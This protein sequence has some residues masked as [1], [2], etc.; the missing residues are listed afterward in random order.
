M[1]TNFGRTILWYPSPPLCFTNGRPI[2]SPEQ[3]VGRSP[4]AAKHLL[5]HTLSQSNVVDA[6]QEIPKRHS[7]VISASVSAHVRLCGTEDSDLRL[8]GQG[9]VGQGRV[10]RGRVGQGRVGQGRVG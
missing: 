8:V 1:M 10:G 3:P 6:R 7:F 2:W 9:R 4:K 5:I